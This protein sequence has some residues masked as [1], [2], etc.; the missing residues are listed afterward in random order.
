MKRFFLFSL[1][2]TGLATCLQTGSISA[3]TTAPTS[4]TVKGR[5]LLAKENT[6]LGNVAV[7]SLK[8]ALSPFASK[9]VSH[10]VLPA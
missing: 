4:I 2:L 9:K 3:Q 6:G 7:Q 10:F 1:L 5:V 8:T